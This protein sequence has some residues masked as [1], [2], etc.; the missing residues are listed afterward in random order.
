MRPRKL[1]WIIGPLLLL[2]L[3]VA[4]VATVSHFFD[5]RKSQAVTMSQPAPETPGTSTE[6][7]T[8]PPG[9]E[10]DNGGGST[11][12]RKS[13]QRDALNVAVNAQQTLTEAQLLDRDLIKQ[14]V[15]TLVVQEMRDQ[16]VEQLV[17][18][19]NLMATYGGY[20]DHADALA[21][22]EY[23][24]RTL[25]Y[26]VD[27]FDTDAGTAQFTLYTTTHFV[28]RQ[29]TANNQFAWKSTDDSSLN[30]VTMRWREGHWLYVQRSSPPAGQ[31][32]E[33]TKADVGL[34][35]EQ[36]EARYKPFLDKGGFKR[37]G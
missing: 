22:S 35:P 5:E 27:S 1:R 11:A 7:S 14:T 29:V 17:R 34:T 36:I 8:N 16:L 3:V 28:S 13:N 37:Y 9:S 31:A 6:P 25:K 18:G 33:F 19:G 30:V 10:G 26:R 24:V 23:S 4:A 12:G 2:F 21:N 32:P 15:D 20:A